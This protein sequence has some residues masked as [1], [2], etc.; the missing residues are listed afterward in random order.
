MRFHDGAD[1]SQARTTR[2]EAILY[3]VNKITASLCPRPHRLTCI[4]S[5]KLQIFRSL[6]SHISH[7]TSPV[8]IDPISSEKELK[9]AFRGDAHYSQSIHRVTNIIGA[10]QPG[11]TCREFINDSQVTIELRSVS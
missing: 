8:G 11:N 3:L 4:H 2:A 10:I 6:R 9:S 7:S 5:I 1:K